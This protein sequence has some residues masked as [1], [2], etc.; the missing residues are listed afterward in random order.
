VRSLGAALLLLVPLAPGAGAQTIRGTLMEFG[1]DSPIDLGLIIM[2]SEFG[3]SV[4]STLTQSN[5]FF[6][7][8]AREPGNYMLTAAALGYRETRV[9][10]FELGRGGEISVEFRLWPAPL[11]L[12][13]LVVESLVQEPELVRNGFY[14]RM[15]RGVG[16]FISPSDIREAEELR[17]VDMLVGLPGLR[18]T[19]DGS[20]IERILVRGSRGLCVPTVLV[21]GMRTEYSNMDVELDE[22]VPLESLYAIEV[23]RG[24]TGIPIEF[25][26]FNDCG[27]LVFWTLRGRR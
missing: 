18:M 25:G 16:T 21:D 10:L 6:E 26:A 12:D 23:H 3:D 7:V 14:R 1:S 11:T 17:A 9:G 27:L 5:G 13:G 24:V 2:V 19:V 22:L 20:G 4:T 15:Q 8:T